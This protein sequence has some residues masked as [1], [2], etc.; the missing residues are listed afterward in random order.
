MSYMSNSFFGIYDYGLG[1][2]SRLI[3]VPVVKAIDDMNSKTHPDRIVGDAI[4]TVYSLSQYIERVIVKM[5]GM[6]SVAQY[7]HDS[8]CTHRLHDIKIPLFFL[9][10]LDDPVLGNKSIPIG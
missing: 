2:Y 6:K 8:S 7:H 9:S 10:A 3:A 5:E 4:N 1:Y